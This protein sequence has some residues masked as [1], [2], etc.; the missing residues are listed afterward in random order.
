MYI[1]FYLVCSLLL[2]FLSSNLSVYFFSYRFIHSCLY[3]CTDWS[4]SLIN[5]WCARCFSLFI[6]L[7]A[8]LCVYSFIFLSLCRLCY[9]RFIFFKYLSVSPNVFL[10]LYTH[11]V[12]VCPHV[13]LG[14]SSSA[15][16][17]RTFPSLPV[18]PLTPWLHLSHEKTS[19]NYKWNK[20]GGCYDSVR[21]YAYKVLEGT[22]SIPAPQGKHTTIHPSG[23]ERH[24]TILD[25]AAWKCQIRDNRNEQVNT[26]P[27]NIRKLTNQTIL[28]STLHPG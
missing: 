26:P 3:G 17:P 7:S 11:P 10:S 8:C 22:S 13:E 28:S 27:H 6:C 15:D 14:I 5:F 12:C 23:R 20:K 9:I 19:P 4:W 2:H 24:W 1:F 25:P 21:R 16:F 18:S